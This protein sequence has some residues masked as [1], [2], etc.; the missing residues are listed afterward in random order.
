MIN[1]RYNFCFLFSR[2]VILL[3]SAL[4]IFSSAFAQMSIEPFQGTRR[5]PSEELHGIVEDELGNKWVASDAGLIK[6]TG[7]VVTVFTR[8]DGLASDVI[9]KMYKDP[10][11]RIWLS[12]PDA[13]LSIIENGKIRSIPANPEIRKLGA[14]ANGLNSMYLGTDGYLYGTLYDA[15]ASY[16]R[17]SPDM[18][19]AGKTDPDNEPGFGHPFAGLSPDA[20]QENYLLRQIRSVDSFVSP[21]L[22]F[23]ALMCKV[24]NWYYSSG[25]LYICHVNYVFQFR[26]FELVHRYDLPAYVYSFL[27]YNGKIFA[28][29]VASGLYELNDGKAE[30]VVSQLSNRTITSMYRDGEDNYWFTTLDRG[31]FVMR[32]PGIRVMYNDAMNII[33]LISFRGEINVL[34]PDGRLVDTSG[35]EKYKLSYHPTGFRTVFSAG[36]TGNE[37]FYFSF[38]GLQK[39]EGTRLVTL[40]RKYFSST[41]TLPNRCIVFFGGRYLAVYDEKR[42]WAD[43]LLY[44]ERIMSV[45]PES[46]STFLAGTFSSGLMR[47]Y[48]R[49]RMMIEPVIGQGRINCMARIAPD[50]VALG[51][52]EEGIQVVSNKGKVLSRYRNLPNRIQ[53]L[54]Y[55]APYLY[56]G[57]KEGLYIIDPGKQTVRGFNNSNGLPFDEVL[58]IAVGDDRL[59]IS[60]RNTAISILIRDLI[61]YQPLLNIGIKDAMVNNKKYDLVSLGSLSSRLNNFS[62]SVDNYSYRSAFNTV[63][64]YSV[65]DDGKTILSDSSS[66]PA[67]NFSLEPGEYTVTIYATDKLLLTR[68]NDIRFPVHIAIPYYRKGWFIVLLAVL[69]VSVLTTVTIMI[70]RRIKARE[71]QKRS[72][73]MKLSDLEA[74]ALQGQMNP[75]FIFNAVNSI[76]DF[77]LNNRNDEAHVFLST[78]A[79]LIRMVLEHNRKKTVTIDEE[80]ALLRLYVS[81]EEQRLKDQIRLGIHIPADM[82]ADNILLPSMLLQPLV[83]NA[84]WHGLSSAPGEKSI[85]IAFETMEENLLKITIS[86]NGK[87]LHTAGK[88]HE[89]V[90]LDIVKE[91]IR[92]A[93][94]K[95]PAFPFF[96]I[97]N[98]EDNRGVIVQMI[99]PLQTAY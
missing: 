85:G 50:K 51:T 22:R 31:L 8:K 41:T 35:N 2:K 53:V 17:L 64:H 61:H 74:R 62:F 57:T 27:E 82:D 18:K 47:V 42:N 12:G 77:I 66:A 60:G 73:V 99:L 30:K 81:I 5:F 16:L 72:L 37:L 88:L 14:A 93:Y 68:S 97:S 84:I 54:V 44:K 65:T 91:R 40:S 38:K 29:V 28:S 92:L 52:N 32:Q 95:E 43:L 1:R 87:G 63:Y 6:I 33:N 10:K 25:Y 98:Q 46:D 3:F 48:F 96:S 20:F 7:N 55:H 24:R 19:H 15:T 69:F 83:E 21:W 58:G 39:F 67:I 70:V 90:G 89:P 4:L 78:F 13:S 80:V 94:E 36:N 76:Q 23:P 26:N 75:H 86:D 79:S 71:L 49:K 9:L 34:L 59:F 45:A 11:G 56:A